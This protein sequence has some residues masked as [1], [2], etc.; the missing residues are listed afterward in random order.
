[1]TNSMQ[2]IHL[3]LKKKKPLECG[4]FFL[5]SS[6]PALHIRKQIL[7]NASDFD[8]LGNKKYE[9]TTMR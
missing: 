2:K 3:Q 6:L 8:W 4:R 1:M 5:S 9:T 7:Q